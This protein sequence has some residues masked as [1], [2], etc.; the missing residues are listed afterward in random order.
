MAS[1]STLPNPHALQINP[2]AEAIRNRK[3]AEHTA[4]VIFRLS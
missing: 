1:P 2:K 3:P 4:C